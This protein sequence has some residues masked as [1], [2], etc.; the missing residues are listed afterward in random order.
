[1]KHLLL[2][3]RFISRRF[4][5]VHYLK[6]EVLLSYPDYDRPNHVYIIDEDGRIEFASKGVSPVIIPE[7]QGAEG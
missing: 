4:T 2:F 3:E 7:E 6:Y 5:D 1:M